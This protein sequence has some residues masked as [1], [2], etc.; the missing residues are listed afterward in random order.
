MKWRR[1]LILIGVAFG[2]FVAGMLYGVIT[3][4][5][6]APDAPAEVQRAAERDVGI[7]SWVM[8]GGLG[9]GVIG[10]VWLSI[11]AMSRASSRS[12]EDECAP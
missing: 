8:M 7:S 5:V 4:G 6:P 2:I 3:V 10:V 1:P 12:R 9:L 11:I